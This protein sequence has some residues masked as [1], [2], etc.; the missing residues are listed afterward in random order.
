MRGVI[1]L[2]SKQYGVAQAE[3]RAADEVGCAICDAALLARAYDL[4]GKADSA[5]AVYERYVGTPILERSTVD[6]M[7][8]AAVHKRLGELY[9]ARGERDKAVRHYQT[10]IGLWKDADPELQAKVTDARQR[11]AALTRG[12]DTRR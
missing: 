7:F 8:L 3:L 6:G 11:L 9:E 5:I 2:Q 1:A 4:D 10:F 12:T